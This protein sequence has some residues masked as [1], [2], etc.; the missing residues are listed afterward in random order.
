MSDDN[1]G[2][3]KFPRPKEILDL[4]YYNTTEEKVKQAHDN[5]SATYEQVCK[6]PM[7]NYLRAV[8][9]LLF[10]FVFTPFAL[11]KRGRV[12]VYLCPLFDVV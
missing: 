10:D 1:N 4:S 6:K 9:R 11:T 8:L 2:I 7:T 12:V 3:V 5:W